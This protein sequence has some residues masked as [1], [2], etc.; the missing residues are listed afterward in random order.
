MMS[1]IQKKK[2]KYPSWD[3]EYRRNY[4]RMLYHRKK[5]EKKEQE[6]KE[7]E[8]KRKHAERA[9]RCYAKKKA[10]EK[11]RRTAQ[12]KLQNGAVACRTRQRKCDLLKC[13]QD[14]TH[15]NEQGVDD[16]GSTADILSGMLEPPSRVEY[17]DFLDHIKQL[18][19]EI[20][21]DEPQTYITITSGCGSVCAP[22]CGRRPIKIAYS[23]GVSREDKESCACKQP[24]ICLGCSPHVDEPRN[25]DDAY[26]DDA[27][28][29]CSA[30][31]GRQ[32]E[33]R[34]CGKM[35]EIRSAYGFGSGR[36]SAGKDVFKC[37]IFDS[38]LKLNRMAELLE[39]RY[40]QEHGR[41]NS[42]TVLVYLGGGFCVQ[43]WRNE[44]T[45]SSNADTNRSSCCS[46]LSMHR[47]T[48]PERKGKSYSGRSDCC[49]YA[50]HFGSQRRLKIG[51]SE[52]GCVSGLVDIDNSCTLGGGITNSV[53]YLHPADEHFSYF[54]VNG[55]R[56][57]GCIMH[58]VCDPIG[59]FD[60]SVG[61]YFRCVDQTVQVDVETDTIRWPTSDWTKFC[62]A[63]LKYVKSGYARQGEA[64]LRLNQKLN[65]E[66]YYRLMR[67]TWAEDAQLW[68]EQMKSHI[69][70]TLDTD[71]WKC[72]PE[73]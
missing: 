66:E 30:C 19:R 39:R 59:I 45:R 9:R 41:L 36:S 22:L 6:E 11:R 31:C 50:M 60:I 73:H 1:G 52:T 49:T 26:D 47:D 63:E 58:G 56:K 14:G 2:P 33:C 38:T 23:R 72:V 35:Y 43:C 12:Q 4:Q 65:K 10:I 16:D 51:F 21:L 42:I 7:R 29:G 53:S 24:S 18:V 8:R 64:P 57:K 70:E 20:L 61:V 37:H 46:K 54:N 27:C 67:E 48:Y 69:S 62:N 44:C 17:N 34:Y 68:A 13:M 71:Q 15:R 55:Y 3:V 32:F 40:P 28:H 5:M 25:D